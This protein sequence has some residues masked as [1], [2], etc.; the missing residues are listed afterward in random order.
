MK[1]L[2]SVLMS[3]LMSTFRNGFSN[4]GDRVKGCYC[5]LIYNVQEFRVSTDYE[6]YDNT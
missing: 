6:Y 1:A 5:V 3:V 4:V 2:M